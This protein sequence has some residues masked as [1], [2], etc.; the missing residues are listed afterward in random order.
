MADSVGGNTGW[1]T[2]Y[3]SPSISQPNLDSPL[4]SQSDQLDRERERGAAAAALN[5]VSVGGYGKKEKKSKKDKED[6]EEDRDLKELKD[7]FHNGSASVK[8]RL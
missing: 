7:K 4:Q 5:G 8:K 3:S 6:K 2:E 1:Q